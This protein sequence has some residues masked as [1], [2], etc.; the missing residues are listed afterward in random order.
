MTPP[1]SRA[2]EPPPRPGRSA[3][4]V[5]IEMMLALAL[6]ALLAALALPRARPFDGGAAIRAKAYEAAA[7]LRA[8]RD[9]ARR[10]D[11]PV[12]TVL[13][14]GRRRLRSGASSDAVALPNAVALRLAAA[15]PGRVRFY[16]DGRSSGG[17]LTL[18]AGA[19]ALSLEIDPLTSAVR[20]RAAG[21]PR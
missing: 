20:I 18:G 16:P 14:L 5:L 1:T 4:F 10:S 15:A 19:G 13:D 21:A 11:R 2:S 3:G 8:D 12:E 17:A 9:A 7:L 6:V